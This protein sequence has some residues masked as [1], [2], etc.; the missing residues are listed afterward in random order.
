MVSLK[1]VIE[2]NQDNEELLNSEKEQIYMSFYEYY[3][4]AIKIHDDF[5]TY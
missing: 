2:N 4:L 1:E 3:E 5:N